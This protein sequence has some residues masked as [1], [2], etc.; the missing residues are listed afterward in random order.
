M[1]DKP[2]KI[3]KYLICG[4]T[5]LYDLEMKPL[6]DLYKWHIH[7]G[8]FDLFYA[9]ASVNIGGKDMPIQMHRLLTAFKRRQ[10]DHINHNG[11]DNRLENLRL[12]SPQENQWNARFKNRR[13]TRNNYRGVSKTRE[14]TFAATIKVSNKDHYLGAFKTEIEAAKAYDVAAIK[15]R[16]KYAY[17]NFPSSLRGVNQNA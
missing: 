2:R 1:S 17:V 16:G 9:R 15:H 8:G 14:G 7:K 4:H 12:V 5:V 11:L 13:N 10:V 3:G 6:L